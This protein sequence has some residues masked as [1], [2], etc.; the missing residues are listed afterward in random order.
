MDLQRVIDLLKRRAWL[1]VSMAVLG[2]LIGAFVLRMSPR[3]YQATSQILVVR[4]ANVN[5]TLTTA[6]DMQT[7]AV[8]SN[9]LNGVR[10]DIG[11]NMPLDALK[12]AVTA[13]ANF[14]SNVM[15]LTFM[16]TNRRRAVAG[17]NALAIEVS[18]YYREIAS[19]R[20]GEVSNFVQKQIDAKRAQ[21]INIDRQLQQAAI[22]SP[23]N[24]DANAAGTI[25]QQI[26]ALEQ[27]RANLEATLVGDQAQSAAQARHLAEIAPVIKQ[28]KT[29]NDPLY[30]NLRAQEARDASQLASLQAQF[31]SNPGIP[32]LRAQV[33]QE[34]KQLAQEQNAILRSS[35]AISPSYTS[36]LAAKGNLDATIAAERARVDAVSQQISSAEAALASVPT[37]GVKLGDLRRQRDI[38]QEEYLGLAGRFGEIVASETQEATVGSVDVID[39]ASTAS[40]TLDKHTVMG[41]VGAVGGCTVLGFALA[42]LLELFDSRVRTVAAVENIYGRPVI[43][44][45]TN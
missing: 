34:Q 12:S 4:P 10:R 13:K 37:A 16:D 39:R 45:V 43:G 5:A 30:Q 29:M 3:E 44:T 36:A 23:Y 42:F 26:L 40:A 35:T 2:L 6:N 9:V 25:S 32:G 14:G 38:I 33:E 21:L 28:E 8:S 20:L 24:S 41:I 15:P 11:T 27:Q 19:S 1:I 18:R 7:L 22:S 17:A 31:T